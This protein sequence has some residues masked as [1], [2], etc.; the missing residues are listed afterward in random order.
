MFRL[1]V[2]IGGV[3]DVYVSKKAP[4]SL[5]TAILPSLT[6]TGRV[7][8]FFVE[9]LRLGKKTDF[10]RNR[11]LLLL[12]EGAMQEVERRYL[13]DSLEQEVGTQFDRLIEAVNRDKVSEDLKRI[14]TACANLDGQKNS[15]PGRPN[16]Q[17]DSEPSKAAVSPPPAAES[18]RHQAEQQGAVH[19]NAESTSERR[20][21]DRTVNTGI[22]DGGGPWR[23][24]NVSLVTV[25]A[26]NLVLAGLIFGSMVWYLERKFRTIYLAELTEEDGPLLN[27]INT[28][29]RSMQQV[30]QTVTENHSDYSMRLARIENKIDVL[31]KT[32]DENIETI[33]TIE[34]TTSESKRQLED[35]IRHFLDTSRRT[36]ELRTEGNTATREARQQSEWKPT[37]NQVMEVQKILQSNDFYDGVIDGKIGPETTGGIRKWQEKNR[38][39]I[40]GIL[41]VQAFEAIVGKKP[42]AA[43]GLG[44]VSDGEA[45]P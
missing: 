13:I 39:S 21:N 7:D 36:G 42:L 38:S 45:V 28:V 31:T 5:R 29:N 4:T 34:V 23:K 26:T 20:P 15:L 14:Y 37:S 16:G 32:V 44:V 12:T 41:D 43:S 22:H 6:T 35:L 19:A 8:G 33:A 25:V 11:Y 30:N 2:N 10:G 9:R 18:D 3:F 1:L 24:R 17:L 27:E 40:T